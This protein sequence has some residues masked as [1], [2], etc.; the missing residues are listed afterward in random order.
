[1]KSGGMVTTIRGSHADWGMHAA[2]VQA[3]AVCDGRG[4]RLCRRQQHVL[5]Q[6]RRARHQRAQA[7]AGEQVRGLYAACAAAGHQAA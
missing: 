3:R 5:A 2:H 7:D 6:P 1:M 4:E